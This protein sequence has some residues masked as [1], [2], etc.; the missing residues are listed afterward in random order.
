MVDAEIPFD[1]SSRGWQNVDP[2]YR[3]GGRGGP[4]TF[5]KRM[6]KSAST[7]VVILVKL[8]K[9]TITAAGAHIYTVKN[10]CNWTEGV[11]VVTI[12]IDLAGCDL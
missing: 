10:N 1:T 7:S 11:M 12:S 2:V 5:A 4:L 3:V 8:Q 6:A 9:A